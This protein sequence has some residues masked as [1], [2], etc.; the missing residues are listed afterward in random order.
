RRCKVGQLS[1]QPAGTIHSQL[2]QPWV[3]AG[4]GGE[5]GDPGRQAIFVRSPLV[6]HGR[7]HGATVLPRAAANSGGR[8]TLA[9]GSPGGSHGGSQGR[10][11]VYGRTV[12]VFQRLQAVDV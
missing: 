12:A 4:D 6:G 2:T 1:P 7:D 11:F 10:V 5:G 3:D 9:G 8:A